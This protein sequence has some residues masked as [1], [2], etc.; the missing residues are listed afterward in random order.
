M[1]PVASVSGSASRDSIAHGQPPLRLCASRVRNLLLTLGLAAIRCQRMAAT[2]LIS[3]GATTSAGSRSA[4]GISRT[5]SRR[6]ATPTRSRPPTAVSTAMWASGA[7]AEHQAHAGEA[8]LDH[9]HR[10][11]AGTDAPAEGRG[12]RDRGEAVQGRL[13]EELVGAEPEAVVERAEDGQR[14]GAEHQRGHDEALDEAVPLGRPGVTGEP[15][16][17]QPPSDSTRDSRRSREPMTPPI[18]IEASTTSIGALCR[19]TP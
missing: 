17:S 4:T 15:V 5:R 18:T 8:A 14:A 7:P 12:E 19:R 2:R 16:W 3:S 6:R 11:R 10:D 1:S 13:E 9:E